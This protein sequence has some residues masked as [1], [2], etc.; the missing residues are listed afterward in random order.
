MWCDMSDVLVIDIESVPHRIGEYEESFPNSKKRA[1]LH[2]IISE[3][4]CVG[5]VN[6]DEV[7]ILDRQQFDSEKAILESLAGVL[8]AHIDSTIVTF[9]G[10]NFDFPFLMLRGA[11]C[12]IKLDLPDKQ[13]LRNLDIY[14]ILGGTWQSDV[15]SCSLSE[16]GWAM[17]GKCKHSSGSDVADWWAH[18]ELGTIADHCKEDCNLTWKIYQ[19]FRGILW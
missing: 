18:G 11:L 5:L 15:V 3:V 16:L 14:D 12:G 10:K 7:V 19:D 6:N 2:A 1:G 8:R 17:Y 13:S 4:V 9:N